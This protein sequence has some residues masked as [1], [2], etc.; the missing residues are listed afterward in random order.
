MTAIEKVIAALLVAL[1]IVILFVAAQ[2]GREKDECRTG[3][4]IP[5]KSDSG[6]LCV[7]VAK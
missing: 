3:G 4:G 7:K 2:E 1:L 5:V 6:W